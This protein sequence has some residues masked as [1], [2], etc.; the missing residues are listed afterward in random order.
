MKRLAIMCA[1]SAALVACSSNHADSEV[2]KFLSD[3]LQVFLDAG[4]LADTIYM[5]DSFGMKDRFVQKREVKQDMKSMDF[6]VQ[7]DWF[8]LD[9]KVSVRPSADG[10]FVEMTTSYESLELYYNTSKNFEYRDGEL[11]HDKD[12]K[13]G[14]VK[15]MYLDGAKYSDVLVF[16]PE[17]AGGA[18]KF[19]RMYY[20]AE[21]GLIRV[22]L[23]DSVTLFRV[24]E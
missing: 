10:G 16:S 19:D 14:W 8:Y 17:C 23:N 18:Y 15:S 2:E 7:G 21:E 6:R 4:A 3:D 24:L 9:M 13:L 5:V 1:A 20:A 22:D 11:V 12:C